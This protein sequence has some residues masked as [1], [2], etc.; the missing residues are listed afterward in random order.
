MTAHADIAATLPA[1]ALLRGVWNT[2]STSPET[3][4]FRSHAEGTVT[5]AQ[6]W[7]ASTVM[8]A[9]LAAERDDRAPV[10]VLG[11]KTSLT[12]AAFLACL[13]TG[14][15]YVPVDAS[16]PAERIND[17]SAQLAQG[18]RSANPKTTIV[19][20][21][22]A[23]QLH[24][25]VNLSHAIEARSLS[26]FVAKTGHNVADE[27]WVTGGETQYIIFT[28]GS[29]GR[30]KGIQVSASNV[31]HF[32]TWLATFPV[33]REGG[34]T[35]LDQASYSFD[36]SEYELV[37]ALTT[38]GCLYALSAGAAQDYA[39]L[40][41]EL[42][43]SCVD[44]WVSTPPFADLCLVDRKFSQDL[45]E[46]LGLF[47]FCGD[48][49]T[50][51]TAKN[52][53]KRFPQARV[54]NTYGPTESTVAITYCEISD[55]MLASPDPLPVGMARPG[56][57]LRIMRSTEPEGELVEACAPGESGEIVICGDTV[58]LGYYND[59]QKNAFAFGKTTLSDGREVRTFRTGDVGHLDESGMLHYE[60]RMGSLVKVNGYR[61]EL[62]DVEN[63]LSALRGIKSAAVV[64]VMRGGRATALRAFVVLDQ[65]APASETPRTI[66]EHL[67]RR[68]P[69]YM[70]PR[71]VKI[72][73]QMPLTANAKI[74]RKLLMAR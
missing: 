18:A 63:H 12:V 61:I 32:S 41:G 3:P 35:F 39:Q 56:T 13:R 29:T 30:P 31:A 8:A 54:A 37:G 45:L 47:L 9:A 52:L 38:G 27:P 22:P 2:A 55:S 57:E 36:L 7:D 26:G 69:S 71:S 74:D 11:A 25:G 28:S 50:H 10:M 60:G 43:E 53:R 14:H 40:F 49:L 66:R 46:R 68:V 42:A 62:G 51:R 64:P 15:A 5:Y 16:M 58:A 48:T 70:V 44:V 23:D 67:M 17:I 65:A 59:A 73:R 20:T 6:L 21:A 4:A 34:K 33:I 72:L 1:N 19:L 24:P